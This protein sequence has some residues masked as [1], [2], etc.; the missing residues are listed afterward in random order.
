MENAETNSS[1]YANN[2]YNMYGC[3]GIW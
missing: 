1:E 2:Y 3:A